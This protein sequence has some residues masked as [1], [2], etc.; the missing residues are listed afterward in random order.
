VSGMRGAVEQAQN[1]RAI[2]AMGGKRLKRHGMRAL[3]GSVY[4]DTGRYTSYNL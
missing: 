1:D 3:T 2:A 4:I